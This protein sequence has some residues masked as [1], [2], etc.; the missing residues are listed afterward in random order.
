GDDLDRVERRPVVHVDER[1]AR[2]RVAARAHPAAHRDV[3]ADGDLTLEEAGDARGGRGGQCAGALRNCTTRR[4][5]TAVG[6]G[7]LSALTSPAAPAPPA[8]GAGAAAPAPAPAGFTSY[9]KAVVAILAFLQFTIILDFMIISP[10]GALLLR[11]LHIPTKKFGL[12]VSVYAFSAAISG[13]LSAGF[14]DP[15]PR[16]KSLLFFYRALF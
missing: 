1:Q 2:L 11:D 4:P 9:Q 5:R 12:V 14:A 6:C 7:I 10:L 8:E 16:K 3:G 13:V 15:L